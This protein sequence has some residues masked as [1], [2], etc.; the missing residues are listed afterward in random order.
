MDQGTAASLSFVGVT[1]PAVAKRRLPYTG[2]Y[3][4]Q[5]ILS[6]DTNVHKS[7]LLGSTRLLHMG[8]ISL[9]TIVG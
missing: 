4:S 5:Q 7:G 8:V 9:P 6:D 3:Y 2:G 1:F